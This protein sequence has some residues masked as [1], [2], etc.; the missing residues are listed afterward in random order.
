MNPKFIIVHHSLT[1][2]G[3]TVSYNAIRDYHIR[4]NGWREIGYHY[5]LELVGEEYAIFKGRM[6]N[7]SGAHCLGFNDN[8]I[9]ICLV[10]NFDHAPPPPTQVALLRKLCRSLMDIYG[11]KM[12]NVLGHRETYQVRGVPVE[13]TC[14]GSAFSM[15]DFV[16][17]L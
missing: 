13:K 14:P 6:D 2:D 17:T 15:E 12:E 3:V 5:L 7:E 1:P 4:V 8:S 9:G 16:K 11:I 10:G